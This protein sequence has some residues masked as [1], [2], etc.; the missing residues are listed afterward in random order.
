ME[1]TEKG[2]PRLCDAYIGF[3]KTV[4]ASLRRVEMAVYVGILCLMLDVLESFEE[5]EVWVCQ[6]GKCTKKMGI[7]KDKLQIQKSKSLLETK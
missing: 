7:E 3:V 4:I 2:R 5:K 1:G 6:W